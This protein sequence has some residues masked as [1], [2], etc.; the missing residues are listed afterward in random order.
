MN[1]DR[2][3][4]W[5]QLLGRLRRPD[6]LQGDLLTVVERQAHQRVRA[7]P[8]DPA[9]D[10]LDEWPRVRGGDDHHLPTGLNVE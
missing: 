4:C 5:Q 9:H 1:F 10:L 6:R 7:A 8:G 2:R 3:E